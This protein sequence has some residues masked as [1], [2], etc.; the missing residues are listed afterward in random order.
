[1]RRAT[2]PAIAAWFGAAV[3]TAA[4]VAPAAFAVLPTRAL[5]GALVGRVLPVLFVTGA[6]LAL[7]GWWAF[8]HR[9]GRNAVVRVAPFVWFI[10]MIVAQ[11]GVTPRIQRIRANSGAALETLTIND[12]TRVSF[13]R[14]HGISVLLLGVGMVGALIMIVDGARTEPRSKV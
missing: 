8:R 11:Y 5:A 4:V 13:G 10:A 9:K 1:M 2:V 6:V 3:L 12:P 14:L 7:V